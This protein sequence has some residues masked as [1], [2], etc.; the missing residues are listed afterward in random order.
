[1]WGRERRREHFRQRSKKQHKARN[2][3][4][5]VRNSKLLSVAEMSN[6]R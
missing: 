6:V 2:T 4:E 5:S 1:M 3:W